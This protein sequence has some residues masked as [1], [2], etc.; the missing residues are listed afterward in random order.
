MTMSPFP[1][2]VT[3]W[4]LYSPALSGQCTRQLMACPAQKQSHRLLIVKVFTSFFVKLTKQRAACPASLAHS[5]L[6]THTTVSTPYEHLDFTPIQCMACKTQLGLHLRTPQTLFKWV[7]EYRKL[8]LVPN[9]SMV[10]PKTRT[11][12]STSSRKTNY[13]K[14]GGPAADST[15]RR[16][17]TTQLTHSFSDEYFGGGIILH[18]NFF[19]E[20]QTQSPLSPFQRTKIWKTTARRKLS[21]KFS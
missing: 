7:Q 1:S 15:H 14:Q 20:Q 2:D 8:I 10:L 21:D 4:L 12:F 18:Q 13:R 5:T 17:N 9:Y 3:G 11:K 6:N 16:S 19:H